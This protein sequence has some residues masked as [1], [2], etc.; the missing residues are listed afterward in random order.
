MATPGIGLRLPAPLLAVVKASAEKNERTLSAEIIDALAEWYLGA[1]S[2]PTPAKAPP[3][4]SRPPIPSDP[5]AALA[6]AE[7]R[8]GARPVGHMNGDDDGVRSVIDRVQTFSGGKRPAY[9]KGQAGA[10]GHGKAKRG[11]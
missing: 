5:R 3:R 7:A 8:T 6:Q 10:P 9:Q 11:R 2:P 1:D 4:P